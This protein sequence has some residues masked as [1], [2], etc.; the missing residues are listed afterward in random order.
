M[1]LNS[2]HLEGRVRNLA[3]FIYTIER[4]ELFA[5]DNAVFRWVYGIYSALRLKYGD[6]ARDLF[7]ALLSLKL[8]QMDPF[9][10]A[11]NIENTEKYL[12]A[13]NLLRLARKRDV[14]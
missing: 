8:Y 10:P 12:D 14:F 1:L 3:W 13:C 9:I 11:D 5:F 4:D 6:A 7:V 2:E